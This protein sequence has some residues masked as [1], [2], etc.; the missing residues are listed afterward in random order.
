MLLHVPMPVLLAARAHC[1][2]AKY[3]HLLGSTCSTLGAR[4]MLFSGFEGMHPHVASSF[5]DMRAKCRCARAFSLELVSL[6]GIELA[7][8][9]LL[10]FAGDASYILQHLVFCQL[11]RPPTKPDTPAMQQQPSSPHACMHRQSKPWV[12]AWRAPILRGA[13]LDMSASKSSWWQKLVVN[14][15]L[16]N[17]D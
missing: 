14:L 7:V 11:P 3:A 13:A 1:W 10:C 6:L 17:L 8:H 4:P 5:N 16:T 2:L 12:L 9:V 15:G